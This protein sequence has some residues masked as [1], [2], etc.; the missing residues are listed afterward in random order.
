MI[1]DGGVMQAG[2][3]I[4]S[5]RNGAKIENVSG[6]WNWFSGSFGGVQDTGLD[7][8]TNRFQRAAEPFVKPLANDYHLTPEAAQAAK[9]TLTADKL[10]LP[11]TLGIPVV[12]GESPIRWQY[13]HPADKERRQREKGLT[14]GAYGQ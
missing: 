10:D 7:A 11:P 1:A 4:A 5:A 9:T 14:A 3:R 2:Q 13:R 12:A 8:A 6:A